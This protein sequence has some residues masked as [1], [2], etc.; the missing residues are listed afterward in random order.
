M[1]NGRNLASYT[2]KTNLLRNTVDK[3]LVH[4]SGKDGLSVVKNKVS[5][6]K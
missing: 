2:E 3:G 6:Y 1:I 5:V 4:T